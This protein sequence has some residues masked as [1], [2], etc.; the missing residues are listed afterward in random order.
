MG[1]LFQFVTDL[2]T[3]TKHKNVSIF[4][5]LTTKKKVIGYHEAEMSP[6]AAQRMKQKRNHA[7]IG[8]A[9]FQDV[10]RQSPRHSVVFFCGSPN[11][12]RTVWNICRDLG[13]RFYEGHS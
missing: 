4:A 12:Q 1:K 5:H 3:A 10:L 11:I 9:S 8:R 2:L 13:F 6:I 7:K